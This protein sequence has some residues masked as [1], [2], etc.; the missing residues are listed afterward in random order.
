M[1]TVDVLREDFDE[2][3]SHIDFDKAYDPYSK[4]FMKPLFIGM[5]MTALKLNDE[6]DVA[7]ELDGAEKYIML[8]QKT[9][10]VQYKEMATDELRH[11]GILLKKHPHEVHEK[12]RQE[13]LKMIPKEV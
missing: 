7:E 13:L 6:D 11:A 10:D 1:K 3:L 4:D 2:A 12:K 8:F 9:G 5:L